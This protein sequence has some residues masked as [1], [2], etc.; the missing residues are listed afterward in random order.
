M[1]NKSVNISKLK[2]KVILY[3]RQSKNSL[4]KYLVNVKYSFLKVLLNFCF[5][6]ET[7]I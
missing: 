5:M 4:N 7:V 6:I 2:R 1:L 3:Q